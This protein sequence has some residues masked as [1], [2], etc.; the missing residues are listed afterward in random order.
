MKIFLFLM[1]ISVNSFGA[2]CNGAQGKY[3]SNPDGSNGGFIQNGARV[4]RDAYV[5]VDS[6]ICGKVIIEGTAKIEAGSRI[7][8][9]VVIQGSPRI[10]DSHIFG[11]ARISGRAVVESSEICQTSLI[12][13]I[14]VINSKYYCQTEDPAPKDPGEAGKKT[15]LGVD[16]DGDGVRDDIEIFINNVLS[17]TAKKNKSEERTAT[18]TLA[19]IF[20][21]ELLFKDSK[22]QILQ[23]NQIKNELYSCFEITKSDEIYSKNYNTEERLYALFRVAGHLHGTEV[24]EDVKSCKSLN[25]LNEVLKKF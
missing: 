21:K 20:Q 6:E 5:S 13:G 16:S 17:N 7:E 2:P 14:K 25:Q 10:V 3:H 11:S 1:F 18:K 22:Q 23:F 8:E 24:P 9:N 19:K 4:P 12:E 15:L